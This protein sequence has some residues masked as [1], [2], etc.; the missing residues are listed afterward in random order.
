MNKFNTFL[1]YWLIVFVVFH[2]VMKPTSLG[3]DI[4]FSFGTAFGFYEVQDFI[5]DISKK[6]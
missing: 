1:L 2:L 3:L 4:V 6:T 5:N